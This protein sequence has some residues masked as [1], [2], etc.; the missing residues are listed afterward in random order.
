M[1]YEGRL[2][3]LGTVDSMNRI[4]AKDCV[5]TVPD[6]VPVCWNFN[7]N[8]M[9]SV[10]GN[11]EIFRD[12]KGLSCKVNLTNEKLIDSEYFVGG[13]YTDVKLHK[14]GTKAVIDAARLVSMSITLGPSDKSLII[15]K[16]KEEK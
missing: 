7:S 1:K 9:S 3:N 12:E 4:F 11:A 13:Y 14:E 16:C 2:L 10:I 5:L 15:R 6:K 8:D